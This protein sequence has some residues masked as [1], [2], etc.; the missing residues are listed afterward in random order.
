MAEN[1]R[2]TDSPLIVTREVAFTIAAETPDARN[3]LLT[4]LHRWMT[5]RNVGVAHVEGGSPAIQAR[6]SRFRST[7]Q[8]DSVKRQ[9]AQ[10]V[11]SR[12]TL[13]DFPP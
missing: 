4:L 8:Q 10:I 1:F 6:C 12:L 2:S 5:A 11:Q 7:I 13:D 9:K 3:L